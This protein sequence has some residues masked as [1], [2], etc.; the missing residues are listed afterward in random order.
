VDARPS[1]PCAAA[2]R[3]VADLKLESAGEGFE[4]S[5]MQILEWMRLRA[6]SNAL[7]PAG[8]TRGIGRLVESMTSLI[9]GEEFN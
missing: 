9:Y 6:Q 8:L 4:I 5:F 2:L 1:P 3:T 7:L